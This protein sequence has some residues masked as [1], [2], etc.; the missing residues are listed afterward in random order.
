MLEMAVDENCF[1]F[2]KQFSFLAFNVFLPLIDIGSDINTG[3]RFIQQGDEDLGWATIFL[4]GVVRW[5]ATHVGISDF[6]K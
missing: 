1:G 3:V 5:N 4:E 6:K 2:S